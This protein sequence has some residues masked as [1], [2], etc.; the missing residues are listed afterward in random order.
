MPSKA[1][2]QHTGTASIFSDAKA[3]RPQEIASSRVREGDDWP[4]RRFFERG[5]SCPPCCVRRAHDDTPSK[6]CVHRQAAARPGDSD[7][8]AHLLRKRV[9][10]GGGV[11]VVAP[12]KFTKFDKDGVI[13][14]ECVSDVDVRVHFVNDAILHQ[15]QGH[16]D[17]LI[18]AR[19][20]VHLHS[21][22][23]ILHF[24]FATNK[25]CVFFFCGPSRRH[26]CGCTS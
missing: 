2:R 18:P 10:S 13:R 6:S 25:S 26:A 24:F 4:R 5:G 11:A 20:N 15:N 12:H 9:D 14:H 8:V 21:S 7:N 16:D 17:R 19:A 1:L 22:M 23:E 3:S